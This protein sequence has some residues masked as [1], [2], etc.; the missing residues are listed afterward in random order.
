M[1]EER[2]EWRGDTVIQCSFPALVGEPLAK[3]S[4]TRSSLICPTVLQLKAPPAAA[5]PGAVPEAGRRVAQ[6]D[7]QSFGQGFVIAVAFHRL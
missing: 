2:S 3:V 4:Q 5:G 6:A 1:F 7:L